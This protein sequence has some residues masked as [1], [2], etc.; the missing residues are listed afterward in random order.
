MNAQ[1]LIDNVAS[2]S[3]LSE[4]IEMPLSKVPGTPYHSLTLY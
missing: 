3:L 1:N 4:W 2:H